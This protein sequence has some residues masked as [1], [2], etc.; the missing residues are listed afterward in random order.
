MPGKI[1][2]RQ[3]QAHLAALSE[4]LADLASETGVNATTASPAT[5]S[6]EDWMEYR[7]VAETLKRIAAD[8]AVL[9]RRRRMLAQAAR[10]PQAAA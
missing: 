9:A 10:Q 8:T 7:R 2:A 4:L 3:M 5:M 6:A 1:T